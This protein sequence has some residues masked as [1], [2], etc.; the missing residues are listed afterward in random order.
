MIQNDYNDYDRR[1]EYDPLY[2]TRTSSRY[3][4]SRIGLFAGIIQILVGIALAALTLADMDVGFY[5]NN[6]Q[7]QSLE[8]TFIWTENPFWPTFGKGLWVGLIVRGFIF[9]F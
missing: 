1:F 8:T 4:R 3:G 7:A 9:N 2:D 6:K 5:N